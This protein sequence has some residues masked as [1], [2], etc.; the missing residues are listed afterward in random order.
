MRLHRFVPLLLLLLAA[1]AIGAACAPVKPGASGSVP[2]MGQSDLTSDQI[3]GFFWANQPP[4]GPCLTVSV[5]QLAADFAWEGNAENVRGDIAFA[6]S[7]VETGW[8]RYGGQ[9]QCWQNNYGGLGATDGGAQ[10]ASFP[11]ADTGVRAQ[12]QHLRAY[13]DPTATSCSVPPLNTPCADPRFD[14]VSPKGKAPT[15][16]Q[17]GNGNWATDPNYASTVI[18]LYNR[19]RSYAGLPPA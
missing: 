1:L 6:Q 7:I 11:D 18:N 5:E 4:G 10:G 19:M 13:A 3:A 12:I 9:V 8:F 17:M 16:N 15:W 2:V 14:F